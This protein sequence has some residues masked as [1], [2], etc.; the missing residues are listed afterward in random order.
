[1]NKLSIVCLYEVNEVIREHEYN[2]YGIED[3]EIMIEDF[4]MLRE[5]YDDVLEVC[6]IPTI[7][8]RSTIDK[9]KQDKWIIGLN[10]CEQI[11][12]MLQE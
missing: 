9:R 7:F 3:K 8:S 12:C 10:K 1:M 4:N 6:L 2:Y 5:I 11:I